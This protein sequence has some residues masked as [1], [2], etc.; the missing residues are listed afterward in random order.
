MSS[1]WSAIGS[2]WTE[3][4]PPTH[5]T[6]NTERWS[7]GTETIPFGDETC[8]QWCKSFVTLSRMLTRPVSKETEIFLLMILVRTEGGLWPAAQPFSF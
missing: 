3:E 6:Q 8:L 4:S 2:S 1:R 5:A 7:G